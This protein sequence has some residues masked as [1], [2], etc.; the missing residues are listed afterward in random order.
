[1]NS[2]PP[3][4]YREIDGK[5]EYRDP[6][7]TENPGHRGFTNLE[8]LFC[9]KKCGKQFKSTLRLANH[10]LEH[11][12]LRPEFENLP[13]CWKGECGGKI[14]AAVRTLKDHEARSHDIGLDE[15]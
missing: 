12:I 3:L 11:G 7:I 5:H 9:C 10:E 2:H 13:R 15:S 1:M 8:K 14:Y 6:P 4:E